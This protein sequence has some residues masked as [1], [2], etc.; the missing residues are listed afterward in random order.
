MTTLRDR[1]DAIAAR[2]DMPMQWC[3]GAEWML[4]LLW[5]CIEAAWRIRNTHGNIGDKIVCIKMINSMQAETN[6]ALEQLE[7]KLKANKEQI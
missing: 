4:E 6:H 3:D 5:P 1:L 7:A 2:D